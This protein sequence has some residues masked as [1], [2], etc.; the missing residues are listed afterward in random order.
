MI[1]A[2]MVF[3]VLRNR[4]RKG[5]AGNDVNGSA[6]PK[7]IDPGTQGAEAQEYR[8][9]MGEDGNRYGARAGE[10]RRPEL[11]D[12]RVKSPISPQELHAQSV[13]K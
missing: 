3:F 9:Q 10:F 8:A 1:V 2:A 6:E 5:Q 11:E 4:R 7:Y 13:V 12:D